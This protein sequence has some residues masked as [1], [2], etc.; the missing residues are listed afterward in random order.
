MT[1]S[2]FDHNDARLFSVREA[3]ALL[4][5]HE[6]TTGLRRL[7]GWITDKKIKTVQHRAGHQHFIPADELRK[8]RNDG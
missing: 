6:G 1:Q 4:W 3:A 8:L 7:R 2:H 5:P